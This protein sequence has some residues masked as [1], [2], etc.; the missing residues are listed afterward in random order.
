MRRNDYYESGP[1][2]TTIRDL[3]SHSA[4]SLYLPRIDKLEQLVETMPKQFSG[5]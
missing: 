2:G 1:C 4:I 3:V 5:V